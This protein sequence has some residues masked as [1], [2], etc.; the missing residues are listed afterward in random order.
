M[1]TID[2]ITRH[3]IQ[4]ERG[5]NCISELVSQILYKNKS[6]QCTSTIPPR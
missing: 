2:Q 3:Y 5:L 6:N 1:K 4:K